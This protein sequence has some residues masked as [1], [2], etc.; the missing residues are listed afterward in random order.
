MACDQ[1]Y[2][3]FT[4]TVNPQTGYLAIH[5]AAS[6]IGDGL[7]NAG[8]T[9]TPTTPPQPPPNTTPEPPPPGGGNPQPATQ[10]VRFRKDGQ[11]F[12]SSNGDR[13]LVMNMPTQANV[14]YSSF[15]VNYDVHHGGWN[16][17]APDGINNM[18]YIT[19]GGWSGDVFMLVTTRGPNK[20]LVRQEITVDL[21]KNEISQKQQTVQLQPNTNYHVEYTYNHKGA[22]QWRLVI[23][24][25][26]GGVVVNMSGPTTGPI[27]TKGGTWKIFFSDETVAAHVSSLGW[28][29]SNL[30][31]EWIP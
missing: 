31:V 10:L 4:R 1:P 8:I 26:G 12:T 23:T 24:E 17:Q 25:Q 22:R 20:N 9:P 6:N 15:K 11:F 3:V 19:R 28:S 18:G 13:A 16:R 14:I 5:T 21:P 7:P 2:F 29:W 30:L 27:W